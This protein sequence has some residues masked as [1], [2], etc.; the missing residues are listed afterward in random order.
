MSPP[1][2]WPHVTEHVSRS[3][4]TGAQ[5]RLAV[6]MNA[7][8]AWRDVRVPNMNSLRLRARWRPQQFQ[9]PSPACGWVSMTS[10][11]FLFFVFVVSI[12]LSVD[13]GRVSVAPGR[14]APQLGKGG[15]LKSPFRLGFFSHIWGETRGGG[16]LP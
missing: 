16:L 4:P 6:P 3:K 7:S 14:P 8:L 12:A 11:Y 5:T 10:S 15:I 9:A 1:V 2:D 13:S